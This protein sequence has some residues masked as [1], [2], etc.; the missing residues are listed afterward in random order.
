[1]SCWA[2]SPWNIDACVAEV[3]RAKR[4]GA[5]G[6]V[7]CSNPHDSGMPNFAQPDWR[8]FWEICEAL[9][10]PIPADLWAELKHESLIREDAPTPA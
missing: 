4:L 1:M 9:E 6:I 7:M 10:M 5:R 2:S 3:E 8:P